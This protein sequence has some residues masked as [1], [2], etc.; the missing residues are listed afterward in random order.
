MSGRRM[1]DVERLVIWALRDEAAFVDDG[2][3]FLRGATSGAASV[4]AYLARGGVR[5]QGGGPACQATADPD[6]VEVWEAISSLDADRRRLLL[7]HGRIGDRPDYWPDI[8]PRLVPRLDDH[9][10][11]KLSRAWSPTRKRLPQYCELMLEATAEEINRH[12]RLWDLWHSG[13]VRVR[14]LLAGGRLRLWEPTGPAVPAHPVEP[15]NYEPVRPVCF[16]VPPDAADP[17]ALHPVHVAPEGFGGD[18]YEVRP[19]ANRNHNRNV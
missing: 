6:A 12:R 4:E 17:A 3:D 8:A 1:I 5:I 7:R 13:L 18:A 15:W 2:G 11:P 10:Q 14:E 16:P 19:Y 9:G